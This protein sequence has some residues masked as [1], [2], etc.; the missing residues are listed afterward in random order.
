MAKIFVYG[1]SG[2]G[3]TASIRRLPPEKTGFINSDRKEPSFLA[4]WRKNY[5]TVLKE[6]PDA[7]APGGVRRTPDWSKSNYVTT[8]NPKTVLEAMRA[9]EVDPRIEYIA[10]D[11]ITHMMGA[12][13]MRRLLEQGYTKFSE[14]G[15][16]TYDILNFIRDAKKNYV[17][18]AHNDVVIDAEGNKVN[19]VRS[20]G[21]LLDEKTEMPS[22]FSC[23]L[24][25]VVK[26]G[27]EGPEFYFQTQSD[28]HNYAKSPGRF[29]PETDEFTPILP[30][31]IKNDI[32]LVFDKLNE[33]ERG[34]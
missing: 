30:F 15:K 9:W 27:K 23:V 20:F 25:P 28:G 6:I 10:L 34:E 21:K 4:G 19:K 8:G 14:L 12:E 5:I 18:F 22:M 33:F 24:T 32:K 31:E 16:A 1:P 17:V 26:K 7:K 3:K 2:W 11:T 29:D 13:F